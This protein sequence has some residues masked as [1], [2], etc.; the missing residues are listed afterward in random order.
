M[1]LDIKITEAIEAAVAEEGQPDIVAKRLIAW[2][3]EINSGNEDLSDREQTERHL[4]VLY[5][6]TVVD[7]GSVG[8]GED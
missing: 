6:G 7:S 5:G 8:G 3:E 4:G 1:S 2:L